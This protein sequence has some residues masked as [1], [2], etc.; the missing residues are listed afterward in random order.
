M[1]TSRQ[2][3]VPLSILLWGPWVSAA[4]GA[5]DALPTLRTQREQAPP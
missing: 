3:L 2:V 5:A 1:V 4:V